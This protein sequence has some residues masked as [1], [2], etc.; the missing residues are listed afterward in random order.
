[1]CATSIKGTITDKIT[2][3]A[4]IGATVQVPNSTLGSITDIEGNYE[5]NLPAG[6]Y[7]LE[8]KYISYKTI[9]LTAIKVPD[10]ESLRLDIEM[11]PE[12]LQL[13]DVT[14]IAQMKRN[15][16]MAMLTA[17]K[18][19]LLVQSG[20]SAQQISRTQDRNASEVIRRVPGISIIEDKFVLVRGL[21]QRYNNVWINNAAVPSTEADSRAFSFDIIPAS[22]LDNLVIVKSPA[23]ELPADF[24]GGFIKIQTRDI[25]ERNSFSIQYG[26]GI[27]DNTHFKNFYHTRGSGTDF[28]GFDNGFRGLHNQV[29]DRLNN[30]DSEEV[31]H[32]T[33]NGFN[34]DWR[35]L[36]KKP[37]P[38]QK[39]N[40]SY[41]R[42]LE[43]ES[44]KTFALL[45]AL[46][47]SLSSK[48]VTNM[49]NS[50]FGIY[51]TTQDIPEYTYKY[52]DNQYTTNAHLGALL[53][54]TFLPENR[55]KYEFKNIFNQIGQDKYTERNGYQYISGM[56]VQEK[57]EYYYNSR[58]TYSGQLAGTYDRTE[59]KFDWEA[60]YN[61]A[62]RRQ[63]DRRI[64]TREENGFVGDSHYGE[65]YVDQN[66]I[67]RYFTRLDEHIVSIAAN[68]TRDIAIGDLTPTFK[69]GAYGE[70]RTRTYDTRFF[71]YIWNVQNMSP[72]FAYGDIIHDILIEENYGADRLFIYE[73][74]DNRNNYKGNNRL[75]AGYFSI[76]LPVKRFNIYA[77]V[78]YE[79]SR[80]RLT[81]NL[82]IRGEATEDRD[83]NDSYFYP[84][85]NMTYRLNERQLFR[86]AYG[87]SVNRPEFREV[88]PSVYYDFDLFSSVKGNTELKT[89]R[90]QNM[91][92][93]YEWYPSAGESVSVALFYKK[94]RNPI[95]WTYLDAGGSYTYTFENAQSADNFGI[96]LDIKKN[97][98]CI[99]LSD[100]S[101]TFNGALIKSDVKF[102]EGS[103]EKDRSMQGQSPYLVNTGIFYH[104]IQARWNIGILYNRIGKRIVGVGRT[105]TSDGGSINNDIP[106]AYEM[107]RNMIDLSISKQIGKY[108]EIKASFRDLLN[109]AVTFKQY[110][111]FYDSDDLL[112]KRSQITKRY[113][114]GRNFGISVAVNL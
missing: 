7:S 41:N 51:N 15:T 57:H 40:L 36:K 87:A 101:W 59:S 72:D 55:D 85:V 99:G 111:K 13:G 34:N 58:T 32:I 29:P 46:N 91:D 97:L 27:N 70:Y 37:L 98:G 79:N 19:S 89:A 82:T 80:M 48:S 50:R 83:Y 67:E 49:E 11:E 1:M 35:I 14:V 104:N 9:V 24:S 81:N 39:L 56:Y 86:L 76:N 102:S 45:S 68:Y 53:N 30:N 10:N 107:P 64:Y 65:M 100:F 28:L 71:Y 16:D 43:T 73:D 74:S 114:P 42:K 90:I 23:P 106:D 31:T 84:S 112:Q 38:D 77:G 21:S 108:V 4:L 47:Y 103:L 6:I 18:N 22:Q 88:S 3:E 8:I 69:A 94:F 20:V 109:E 62:N 60:G 17:Q 113:K 95:E 2:T 96:E 93:R 52:T 5:L 105:D 66:D 92:L 110:P 26:T 63:P 75:A 33:R 44:G 12:S 25:P 78:R 54:L 61:Y